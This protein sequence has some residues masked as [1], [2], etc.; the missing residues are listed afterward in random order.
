MSQLNPASPL[1][2]PRNWRDY[3][4][5]GLR[6]DEA[7]HIAVAVDCV[8]IA[9]SQRAL[10][11]F[12]VRR[13]E[14]PFAGCWSLPGGY[15]AINESLEDGGHRLF[16]SRV[17]LEPTHLE[18]IRTFG[19]PNRDPRGRVVSVCFLSLARPAEDQ[20]KAAA[21][22]ENAGWFEASALPRL[23]FDH[24]EIINAAMTGLRDKV[25]HE[26]LAFAMLPQ[27]FSLTQLQ[28][29][30][31]ACLG[32]RLDKRNF[33]KKIMETGTLR[34]LDERQLGVA[35]RA[36]KLYTF[37]RAA[38]DAYRKTGEEVSFVA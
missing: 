17:G 6:L 22:G 33:R 36:A 9:F 26:P 24:A 32:K 8:P 27:K 11:V 31:E 38:Y 30:Y 13:N 37:D 19:N 20:L 2:E 10:R 16:V 21:R 3:A 7:A 5:P 4:R 12:L 18:Q 14:E 15:V 25:R 23:A 28:T 1:N 34:D 35:H 29:L